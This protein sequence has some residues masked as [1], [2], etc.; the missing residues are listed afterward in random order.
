MFKDYSVTYAEIFDGAIYI[1]A[2]GFGCKVTVTLHRKTHSVT[3]LRVVEPR[4]F[5][6]PNLPGFIVMSANELETEPQGTSAW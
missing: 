3:D 4:R 2:E 6:Q 1:E 5:W